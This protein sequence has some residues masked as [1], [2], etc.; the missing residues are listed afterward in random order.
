MDDFE[1]RLELDIDVDGICKELRIR[2]EV[3]IRLAISFSNS[4]VGKMKTLNEAMSE[5]QADQM[6]MILHEIKGTA[7][8]LRLS[9]IS[10]AEAVMHL[11]VKAGENKKTIQQHFEILKAETEKLQRYLTKL[12]GQP[13]AQ[14]S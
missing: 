1:Q 4:L 11:A 2:P 7:G 6:R 3:Y 14:G 5:N 12:Y 8:N 9:N 13:D 10:T